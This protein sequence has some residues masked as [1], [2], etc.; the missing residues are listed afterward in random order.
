MRRLDLNYIFFVLQSRMFFLFNFA[1]VFETHWPM[2]NILFHFFIISSFFFFFSSHWLIF[3]FIALVIP[4][5][6]F[7]SRILWSV[8][9]NGRENIVFYWWMSVNN[10]RLWE[11]LSENREPSSSK[12]I[13][14]NPR[15]MRVYLYRCTCIQ[16]KKRKAKKKKKK[17]K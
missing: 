3:I 1:I 4:V 10:E 11:R 16:K 7:S 9:V 15:T 2:V 12:W 14:S 13:K 8:P 6:G 17:K 5:S